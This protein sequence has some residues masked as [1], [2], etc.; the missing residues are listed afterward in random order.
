MH[1]LCVMCR[2]C[3]MCDVWLCICCVYVVYV[4]FMCCVYVVYVLFMCVCVEF[5]FMCV[6]QGLCMFSQIPCV[7]RMCGRAC[8]VC[9]ALD[10][11]ACT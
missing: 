3:C 5:E 1:C 4:L 8:D 7:C 10:S 11:L 2:I 9:M 6:A